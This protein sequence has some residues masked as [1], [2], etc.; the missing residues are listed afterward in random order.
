MRLHTP[1]KINV[2]SDGTIE[3]I[4]SPYEG[5]TTPGWKKYKI[6]FSINGRWLMWERFGPCMEVALAAAK[7]SISKEY[8][9]EWN[10]GI[11]IDDME[12]NGQEIMVKDA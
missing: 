9:E 8:G 2:Y 7:L 3:G 6:R 1:A 12:Q 4:K 10:G 5:K 11:V